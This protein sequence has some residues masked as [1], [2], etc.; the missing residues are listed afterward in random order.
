MEVDKNRIPVPSLYLSHKLFPFTV[1]AQ[2]EVE[3]NILQLI[4]RDTRIG[5]LG[6]LPTAADMNEELALFKKNGFV[7]SERMGAS[8][9][10]EMFYRI[11][12]RDLPVFITADAVLAK[13]Y[14][15]EQLLATLQ[16]VDAVSDARPDGTRTTYRVATIPGDGVGPEVIAAACRV[17]DAAGDTFDFTVDWSE[18]LV[19][20][21]AIDAYGVAIRDEDLFACGEAGDQNVGRPVSREVQNSR[22]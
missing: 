8:S 5:P 3:K 10:G 21:A 2:G 9:F 16:R 6:F 17:V 20:G 1:I 7:V 19:G 22:R 13:P 14:L 11:Y 18:H 12:S 15:P 4:L